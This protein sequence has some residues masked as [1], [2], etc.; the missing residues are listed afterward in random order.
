MSR[1]PLLAVLLSLACG[2]TPPAQSPDETDESPPETEAADMG[3]GD[4]AATAGEDEAPSESGSKGAST[5]STAD[6]QAILQLVIDDDALTP[7]LHLELPER[8]PLRIS[9]DVLPSGIELT[10]GTKPAQIVDAAAAAD[11]KK[12][13]LVFTEIDFSGNKATIAYRYDIEKVRGTATVVKSDGAWTLK[14]S[15][16]T[17]REVES[18]Q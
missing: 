16:V 12:P 5:A 15:R 7:Y 8:F 3:G 14:S 11:K 9:G 6:L 1:W 17:T 10:K 13:V 4:E 2:S 18:S